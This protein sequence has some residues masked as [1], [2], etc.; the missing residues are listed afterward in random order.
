M[1]FGATTLYTDFWKKPDIKFRY[2][3]PTNKSKC[4]P[5]EFIN[6]GHSQADNLRIRIGSTPHVTNFTLGYHSQNMTLRE[7]NG[8]WIMETRKFPVGA[9]V[10]VMPVIENRSVPDWYFFTMASDQGVKELFVFRNETDT[11]RYGGSEDERSQQFDSANLLTSLISPA[12]AAAVAATVI[13]TRFIYYLRKQRIKSEKCDVYFKNISDEVFQYYVGQ[14]PEVDK[15]AHLKN[16]SDI[17]DSIRRDFNEG[18]MTKS[19]FQELENK[20]MESLE[21]MNNGGPNRS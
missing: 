8:A 6:S 10:R 20:I 9:A 14:K 2:F 15:S 4:G 12:S 1:V 3:S 17:R 21:K 5:F 16:L 13:S 11:Y 7:E 18:I 19:D